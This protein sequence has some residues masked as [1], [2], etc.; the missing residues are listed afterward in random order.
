MNV[1]KEGIDPKMI[2]VGRHC[3]LYKAET[4]GGYEAIVGHQLAM[5]AQHLLNTLKIIRNVSG[6]IAD[7]VVRE[8]FETAI[9]EALE[10][11]EPDP[12]YSNVKPESLSAG[13]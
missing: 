6:L 12:Y 4:G 5:N 3:L 9:R 13:A 8:K 10:K 7:E 11:A 2:S 1:P